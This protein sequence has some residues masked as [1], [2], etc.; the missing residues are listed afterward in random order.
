MLVYFLNAIHFLIFHFS[1]L[2]LNFILKFPGGV[3]YIMVE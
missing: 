2:I 3:L 1:F